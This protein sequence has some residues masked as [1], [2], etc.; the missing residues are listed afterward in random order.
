MKTITKSTRCGVSLAYISLLIDSTNIFTDPLGPAIPE[1][2]Q[3]LGEITNDIKS[4]FLSLD[5]L[6][7][8]GAESRGKCASQL[9]AHHKVLEEKFKTINAYGRELHHISTHLENRYYLISTKPEDIEGINYHQFIHEG[10]EF[11]GQS[12]TKEDEMHKIREFLRFLPMRMTKDSFTDYVTKSL[13]K[14]ASNP[15]DLNNELFLSVFKQMF[16]GRTATSYG[17]TFS[18]IY[19]AIEDLRK[20][21]KTDITGQCIEGM[22]DDIYLLQDTIESLS[23]VITTLHNAISSLSI[24]LLLDHLTLDVLCEEH[25]TFN[26]FFHTV[27]SLISDD[28]HGEDYNIMVETLPDRLSHVFD[29]INDTYNKVTADFYDKLEKDLLPKSEESLQSIKVFSLIQYYLMLN[30][31]DVFSFRE[32]TDGANQLPSS[33]VDSATYFLSQQFETLKAAERKVRMQYLMSM[34]PFIMDTQ[35]FASY[36]DGAIEG[37]SN[38]VQKA[39]VL[40]KLS[41]FMDSLGFFDTP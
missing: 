31:E 26:D 27:K 8:G 17:T 41:N 23:R 38:Q 15:A 28:T 13:K 22:F 3:E 1:I 19:I 36:F 9:Q 20:Q 14:V 29:E 24:L 35:E 2:A 30:V 5:S 18:D 37:T 21:S 34:L 7:G 6:I 4:Y 16:D 39:Y 10:L 32:A 25:I 11:I 33:V 12:E 40:T